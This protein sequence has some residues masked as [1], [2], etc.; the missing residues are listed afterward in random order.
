MAGGVADVFTYT[1]SSDCA[2]TTPG[3]TVSLDGDRM[4][5]TLTAQ[6]AA[7]TIM[8]LD[9]TKLMALCSDADGCDVTIGETG[10]SHNATGW[11]TF[12]RCAPATAAACTCR[13]APRS[14]Y[15]R[16]S[17]GI[18]CNTD[19]GS[20]WVGF[21]NDATPGV[22]LDHY[23]ACI[24]MDARPGVSGATP[25]AIDGDAGFYF[26]S[27][28]DAWVANGSTVGVDNTNATW[29]WNNGDARTCV[30]VIDD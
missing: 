14:P 25:W 20:A 3:G 13:I 4:V 12:P 18:N 30:L 2:P 7:L 1:C 15:R 10:W 19:F 8:K 21:D 5:V 27:T 16:G 24:L 26:F 9:D 28:Y 23:H 22:L 11:T 6:A 29:R 17:V